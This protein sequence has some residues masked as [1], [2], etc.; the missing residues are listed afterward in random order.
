MDRHDLR[1][2]LTG[3]GAPSGQIDLD[4]LSSLAASLQELVTRVG[5]LVIGQEGPGRT[6]KPAAKAVHLRLAGL[7]AGSTV[8][9]IAFGETDVLPLDAGVE[10][11]IADRFWEVVAGVQAG[12]RP[13]WV[14]PP[15]A[16]SALRVIDALGRAA[17]E[18]EVVMAD[19]RFAAWRRD[20]VQRDPWIVRRRTTDQVAVTV[21]GRLEKVDLR[22]R[23]FRIRDDV[24]NGINLADVVDADEAAGLVGTRAVATGIPSYDAVG[25]LVALSGPTVALDVPPTE[26]GVQPHVDLDRLMSA[27]PGPD[28]NGVEGLTDGDVDAFLALINA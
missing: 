19:G 2:R 12:D 26:W 1:L 11:A 23:S 3:T 10:A 4:S 25:R 24:G 16:A 9:D 6:P 14:T 15:V 7:A 20:T 22:D 18:V 8:L 13:G 27:A 5:R 21:S 28:P 17:V